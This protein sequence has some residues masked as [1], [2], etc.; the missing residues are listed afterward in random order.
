MRLA[1]ALTL[2]AALLGACGQQPP[3]WDTLLAGKIE[4]QYPDYRVTVS[5]PGVLAV[6]R[7]GMSGQT[8]DVLP[9]AQ[10]CLRGPKDCNY[11][12]ERMLLMLRDNLR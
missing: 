11:A 10:H 6:S 9:I 2:M 3:S 12:V 5:A 1:V 7:P 8:V 4:G